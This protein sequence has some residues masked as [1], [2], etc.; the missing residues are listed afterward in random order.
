MNMCVLSLWKGAF[1]V[2]FALDRG[3]VKTCFRK[4]DGMRHRKKLALF[5]ALCVGAGSLVITTGEEKPVRAAEAAVEEPVGGLRT[6]QGT[7]VSWSEAQ[8][9]RTN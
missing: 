3:W 6:W 8:K 7:Q 2:I 5:L 9:F 1:C 4:D